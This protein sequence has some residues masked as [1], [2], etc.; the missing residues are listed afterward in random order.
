MFNDSALLLVPRTPE[1]GNKRK[2]VKE[3]SDFQQSPRPRRRRERRRREEG[4]ELSDDDKTE[5]E[6]VIRISDVDEG[7]QALSVSEGAT[8]VRQ[9]E[10]ENDKEHARKIQAYLNTLSL[11][12]S[13]ETR[14]QVAK[15]NLGTWISE[16]K[17]LEFKLATADTAAENRISDILRQI[18]EV[19]RIANE[20]AEAK[21]RR[22]RQRVPAKK[23]EY[24][25]KLLDVDR[26]KQ[27]IEERIVELKASLEVV[28]GQKA[29]L[30]QQGGFEVQARQMQ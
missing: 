19:I 12:K 4:I 14:V 20:H 21:V 3:Y 7:E 27:G 2:R 11:V 9:D 5:G 16:Q 28:K 1:K 22:I 25:K 10:R 17:T 13:G 8:P 29:A 24:E 6:G 23:A 30:K 15:S 26:Q 18:D